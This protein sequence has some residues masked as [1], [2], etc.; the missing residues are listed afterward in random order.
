MERK[1]IYLVI[2]A[3]M[4]YRIGRFSAAQLV[5][6]S[7]RVTE[8]VGAITWDVRVQVNSLL[9]DVFIA[10]LTAVGNSIKQ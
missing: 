10:Q 5:D 8:K 1:F 3:K 9:M 7:K 6:W 4:G 2:P